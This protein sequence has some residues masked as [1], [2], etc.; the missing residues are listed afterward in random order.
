[1][2]QKRNIFLSFLK[3]AFHHL[4]TLAVAPKSNLKLMMN[5]NDLK[6]IETKGIAPEQIAMQVEQFKKG[7]P[8]VKLV[9]AAT[10][11]QGMVKLEEKQVDHWINFFDEN[12]TKYELLK[13]VP[14]SGAA[15]RM[16]KHLFEF[17]QGFDG[18]EASINKIDKQTDFNSVGY[19]LKNIRLFAFYDA[20]AQ[21]A[22]ATGQNLDE[23]LASKAYKAVVELLLDDK[24]LGYANLPKALLLFHQ[25]ADGSRLAVEEHLIEAANYST[26]EQQ[27]AKVHFTI[28]PEHRNRFTAAVDAVKG[29][30]AKAFGVSYD[31]AYSEQKPSTDTIAVDL[32][33]NPF[34]NDD[35][36]LLFRPG[37]HGALIENLN[38]L[39]EEI[40]FIKNIDNIVPDHLREETYRYK[41]AIGG[42]LISLQTQVFDYLDILDSGNLE[43]GELEEIQTF[44]DKKLFINIPDAFE[45]F[46][47]I[48]K[49]DFL[50]NKL[51]RPIRVCGM[52]KNEANPAAALFG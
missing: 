11:D 21:K 27:M 9:A 41:K 44:A 35:E 3:A 30:Y 14:A 50:F 5:E 46:S 52:V 25:Y 45:G 51:N 12:K 20:L 16:F 7:F 4:V 23:L 43:P 36:S 34:R 31:I 8:Y 48:E 49:I 19:F 17:I 38:E 29:K 32:N 39:E 28:S 42:L 40:I 2:N 13:F 6:Q 15:S 22:S 37:G 18:S 1:M 24:G 26:N 10:V 47:D 33:N